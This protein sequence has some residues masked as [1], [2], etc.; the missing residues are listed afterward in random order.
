MTDDAQKT[1]ETVVNRPAYRI[2][3]EL[4]LV[5][6]GGDFVLTHAL[7]EG[8]SVKIGRA[9]TNDI[10]VEDS[11][12]S[13]EHAVLHVGEALEIEDLGSANGLLVRGTRAPPNQRVRLAVG[14]TFELGAATILVQRRSLAERPRR[15]WEHDYF[16]GRVEDEC[17]RSKRR[18]LCFAIVSIAG[19]PARE[20][21]VQRAL[22]TVLRPTDPV[23]RYGPG[24]YEVLV[25]EVTPE[26]VPE[27]VARYQQALKS[28]GVDATLGYSR[29][30]I[31]GRTPDQLLARARNPFHEE[32]T[33]QE[34]APL[35]SADAGRLRD[36]R[37]LV[38]RIAPSNISVLILGETGV[39]KEVMAEE[40]HRRSL[41]ARA[42]FLRLHCAA[43]TESLL[44][45]E[46]FGHE[47]GAF[48]GAVQAKQ[49]LLESANGGTVFLDEI[50]E[51]PMS[52]QVKL[53][54]V[55]EERRVRRVGA[56][57]SRPIDV[58]IVAATNRD[59]E[60][61]ISRGAFRQD[62]YFRING[63]SLLIPPLRERLDEI[64]A[65]TDAVLR[66]VCRKEG[67]AQVPDIDPAAM[68]MIRRYDWPGNIRELRNVLER[69][70]LL[71]ERG[72]IQLEHLPVSKM[73]ATVS[74]DRAPPGEWAPAPAAAKVEEATPVALLK[75]L[76]APPPS[77]PSGVRRQLFNAEEAVQI[78]AIRDALAR[79]GGSQKAAAEVLGVSRRTLIN[80]LIK[81]DL[82]RPRKAGKAET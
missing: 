24:V 20:A 73:K 54:R 49:G 14:E 10:Q 13:R 79:C 63:V 51:L 15:I 77:S 29:F 34:Y 78:A 8:A 81:Y 38:E 76:S 80:W 28:R 35:S 48:T 72:V 18:G 33:T 59:L 2:R 43:L 7:P 16:E 5:V 50:G 75:P 39:G 22:M 47:R 32:P 69:A 66:D 64:A 3:Q 25:V 55:L 58:R 71:A 40:I 36:L 68:A 46:L 19:D 67:R 45:S 4:T 6:L 1:D 11:S 17:E 57:E 42:P 41:R 12:V 52:M 56:L 31:D 74:V 9:P 37:R 61:E 82:P 21:E 65:L 62:L 27:I 60:S 44:E 30:G 70:V 23:G 53:L 26:Q